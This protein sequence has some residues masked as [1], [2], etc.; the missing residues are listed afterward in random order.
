MHLHSQNLKKLNKSIEMV[1]PIDDK[2]RQ[3]FLKNFVIKTKKIHLKYLFA[4][5]WIE[6]CLFYFKP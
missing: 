4:C 5:F 2:T 3:R 1:G 6:N